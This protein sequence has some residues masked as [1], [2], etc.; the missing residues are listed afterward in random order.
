[1]I[2]YPNNFCLFF[3]NS[4]LTFFFNSSWSSLSEVI[5]YDLKKFFFLVCHTFRVSFPPHFCFDVFNLYFGGFLQV[6]KQSLAFCLHFE[7]L[8]KYWLEA[9]CGWIWLVDC[10]VCCRIIGW[11]VRFFTEK[12]LSG[13]IGFSLGMRGIYLCKIILKFW[14]DWEFLL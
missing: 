7:R 3:L 2:S 14:E 10:K 13:P 4:I 11:W 12:L 8:K 1:M 9:P 6:I 5:K